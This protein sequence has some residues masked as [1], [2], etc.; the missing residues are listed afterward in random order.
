[1]QTEKE[2]NIVDGTAYDSRTPAELV[3]ILE[4]LRKAQTRVRFTIG[5]IATGETW[6]DVQTGRIGRSFG[7]KYSIPLVIHNDRSTGGVALFDPCIVR[8]EYANK[9]DGNG[10]LWNRIK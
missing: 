7:G 8:I 2:Y 1:M 10:F 4:Q 6:G 3:T 9:K 5:D